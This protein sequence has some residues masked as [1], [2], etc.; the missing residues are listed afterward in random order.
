MSRESVAIALF[1]KISAPM[2]AAGAITVSRRLLHWADVQAA[3]QPAVFL[4]QGKSVPTQSQSGLP[5]Q[6]KASFEVYIYVHE[7]DPTATPATKLNL[8]LD[9]LEA[10]LA[11]SSPGLKQTLGGAAV[12]CWISGPVETDEGTLGDQAVAIVPIEL[13]YV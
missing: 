11:P 12:H 1:N 6:W 10:A 3:D 9:A 5:V 7:T 4:P 2:T 13:L 8:L